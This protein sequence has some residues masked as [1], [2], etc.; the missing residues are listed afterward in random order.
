MTSESWQWLQKSHLWSSAPAEWVP[1][2]RWSSFWI[3]HQKDARM[4]G[5][6]FVM[7]I[8]TCGAWWFVATV[9]ATLIRGLDHGG[10]CKRHSSLLATRHSHSGDH[11]FGQTG[12][13]AC[14]YWRLCRSFVSACGAACHAWPLVFVSCFVEQVFFIFTHTALF[15]SSCS[16][17]TWYDDTRWTDFRPESRV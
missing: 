10:R 1:S 4:L 9:A 6:S 12:R 16:K 3:C 7:V 8:L 5:H 14:L 11:A 15:W 2:L 17:K 13:I